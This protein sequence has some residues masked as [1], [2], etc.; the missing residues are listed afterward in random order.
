MEQHVV[1]AYMSRQL[2]SIF[3]HQGRGFCSRRRFTSPDIKLKKAHSSSE[4][5]SLRHK[6]AADIAHFYDVA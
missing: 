4:S 3:V 1:S 6:G 2:G 5:P